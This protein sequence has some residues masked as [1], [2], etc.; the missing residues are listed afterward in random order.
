MYGAMGI[1]G[2][3]GGGWSCGTPN[4]LDTREAVLSVFIQEN[5]ERG[6]KTRAEKKNRHK[7]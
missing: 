1:S 2:L 3:R 6:K 7:M 5:L 4:A